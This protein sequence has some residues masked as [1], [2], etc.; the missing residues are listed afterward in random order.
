MEEQIRDQGVLI[1]FLVFKFKNIEVPPEKIEKIWDEI[2]KKLEKIGK[3][4]IKCKNKNKKN[5][6]KL[7]KWN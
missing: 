2:L 7:A 1:Y 3:M 6:Q 5:Y 4:W